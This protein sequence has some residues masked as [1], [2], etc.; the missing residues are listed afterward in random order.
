MT[1]EAAATEGV[2]VTR[3]EGISRRS[4]LSRGAAAGGA[5][6]LGGAAG[7]AL[8]GCSSAPGTGASSPN[9]KPGVG[10]GTP[11]RGGS[12]TIGIPAEIDG[13][14]PP[15]NHWDTNGF[16]YANA[17][18]D[19][20]MYVATDGSIQP[21][22]AQSLT[23][24]ATFDVWTLTLRPGIK[25][26]D[27]SDL[28]AAVIVAN[29]NALR[30]SA[31][32]SVPLE[33]IASVKATGDHTVAFTLTGPAARFPAA[34][35]DSQAA[36]PVGQAMIDQANAGNKTPTPIGTGPFVYAD[37]QP[38]DHFTATRNPHYW[39]AGLPYLD[40]IT[41]KPI[42]DTTQREATLTTGA[43][44]LI[45]STDPGT[46]KRF[47]GQSAYQLVDSR[48]GVIGEPTLGFIMLNT[49]VPPVDDLRVRQ[50]LAKG[51][52]QA[53]IQ[54]IFDYGYGRPVNGL[55]LPGSQYYSA[56]GFPTFD[57]SAAKELVAAYKAE[58]G[59]PVIELQTITD[60]L[61]ARIVQVLQQMWTEV[62]FEVHIATLEQA[63]LLDNFIF[64]TYQAGT[65]YQFGTIDPD[66]NY[67]WFSSKTAGPVGS[68]GLNF[69]RNKDPLIDAAI[70]TG[71]ASNDP[72]VRIPAYRTLNTRLA[73][74]LPYIWLS[75]YF[76]SAVAADRV[77]N[78]N[79]L[80]LPNGMA[81]YSFNEGI[82]FPTQI[83]L[84]G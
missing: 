21:Y 65:I 49:A 13:F 64:G 83:W 58:H 27:G 55:F 14:Y 54:Y 28:T 72:A 31:L 46:I 3:Q 8:A 50:A 33:I 52:N 70:A 69:A 41:F 5:V 67:W 15:A 30:T 34:L 35:A 9:S 48:T 60:P 7:S 57:P 47:S 53:A 37:W 63:A 43:V 79:N 24:N 59:T 36:Y 1:G 44:D 19:P 26:N 75:Q 42:P 10:T 16:L 56:T 4:F 51:T 11:V 62:G 68:V 77:R 61:L 84:S 81:G 32:T 40:Q 6:V 73:K 80:V 78:F 39:R 76:F 20:L 29:T 82:I 23:P 71:R 12:L 17:V 2:P 74:D 18:Y 45:I 38:N 25:F 22:L 66:L